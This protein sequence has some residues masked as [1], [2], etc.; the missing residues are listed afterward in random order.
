M[1]DSLHE[2]RGLPVFP[3]SGQSWQRGALFLKAPHKGLHFS[4]SGS[5]CSRKLSG[6]T[7]SHAK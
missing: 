6:A 7:T 3:E 1:I 4:D 5:M 2:T